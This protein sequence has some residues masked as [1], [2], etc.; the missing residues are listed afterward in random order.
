MGG[1]FVKAKEYLTSM[2]GITSYKQ[3]Y[4]R[5][6]TTQNAAQ[7][8]LAKIRKV[9]YF[10]NQSSPLY[11]TN[12]TEVQIVKRYLEQHRR[13]DCFTMN[14]DLRASVILDRETNENYPAFSAFARN[15]KGEITGVQVVYLN[16]QTCDKADI[17]VPRRAFGKI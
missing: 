8:E 10:Y 4:Q 5:K 3:N 13:I 7:N 12:N 14:S 6:E 16:S 9:Q 17:S 15:A 1:D 2:V 11:F